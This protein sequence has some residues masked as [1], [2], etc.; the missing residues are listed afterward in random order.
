MKH[1]MQ[2][3][4]KTVSWLIVLLCL[5]KCKYNKDPGTCNVLKNEFE[6]F[7]K[8]FMCLFL[9]CLCSRLNKRPNYNIIAIQFGY[10]APFQ[11]IRLV[12]SRCSAIASRCPLEKGQGLSYRDLTFFQLS[13]LLRFSLKNSC[14]L[15]KLK[16]TQTLE[17]LFRII[18]KGQV[19]QPSNQIKREKIEKIDLGC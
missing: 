10:S 18:L 14:I 11:V 2:T 1:T 12:E 13:Y 19:F 17:V 15:F 7:L 8:V 6:W 4:E 5:F 16:A 9:L 3:L